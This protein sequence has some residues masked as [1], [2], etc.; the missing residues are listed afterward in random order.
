MYWDFNPKF[1]EGRILVA[2]KGPDL[3]VP[4]DFKSSKINGVPAVVSMGTSPMLVANADA[5]KRV[6]SKLPQEQLTVSSW[7]SVDQ[8]KNYGGIVGFLQDNG[9]N[10]SG[11]GTTKKV[12]TSDWRRLKIKE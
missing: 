9:D 11:L 1:I 6:L 5:A 10:E 7:V 4:D 12:S 3:K 2:Q 8:S